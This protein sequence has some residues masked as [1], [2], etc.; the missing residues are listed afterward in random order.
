MN[1][2]LTTKERRCVNGI[3]ALSGAELVYLVTAIPDGMSDEDL[4]REVLRY[5]PAWQGYASR[6]SAEISRRISR[7][8]CE[9]TVIYRPDNT[10]DHPAARE[11]K[12]AG[13]EI[14][15]FSAGSTREKCFHAF[16]T[17]SYNVGGHRSPDPGLW[18]GWNGGI[19]SDFRVSGTDKTVPAM[20]EKC[21]HTF[22][23]DQ[24]T[25]VYKREVMECIGYVNL[26]PFHAW[27]AGEVL[28]LEA[29]QSPEFC[30]ERGEWLV[31]VAFTFAIS[32][33]S[34]YNINAERVRVPPWHVYWEIAGVSGERRCEYLGRYV[35]RIYAARDFSG[36]NI[37]K[38]D[39]SGA[40]RKRIR[41]LAGGDR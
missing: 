25:N 29:V 10:G 17:Q 22:E 30:N 24:L 38:G 39:S 16:S 14:W 33:G 37:G 28:F 34:E 32:A 6:V 3:G 27:N 1:I 31:D 9:I 12:R 21:I 5:S 11:I 15:T 19:G 23:A 8:S 2:L 41:E 20:R 40:L 26:A 35:S 36:L 4:L 7:R 18:I 13:D